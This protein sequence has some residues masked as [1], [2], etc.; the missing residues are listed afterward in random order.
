MNQQVRKVVFPV[1][2]LGTRFLPATKSMPKEMLPV[3]DKPLI[4]HAFEEA[5]AAGIEQ[6][7]FITGR[8]KDAINNHFDHAYE[9]QSLLNEIG[10]EKELAY[11]RDW[12]PAPGNA[13]FIRQQEPLG[14]G[15][16]VWCARHVVG[17]EPFAV[18]LADDLVLGPR[19]CL[20]QMMEVYAEKPGCNLL[21]VEEIP[22]ERSVRY[23][24][25][26]IAEDYG[27]LV[28]A[29]GL[30][31]KPKPEVAPS[32]TAIM[33]RYI[34]QPGIFRHLEETGKGSGGEIQ[35]TD[36]IN[37]MTAETPAYGF[38]FDGKRFDC[39]ERAGFIEANVAYALKVPG[40]REQVLEKLRAMLDAEDHA[41]DTERQ[42]LLA[43]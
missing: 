40:L 42:A 22:L 7:I 11:T 39:G 35:L 8:N 19:P 4:H 28:R 10:R 36:A 37:R 1:G 24:I 18:M 5:L 21:G 3:V 23:G 29:S 33:G 16:A 26:D 31:E 2:G 32:T 6:F 27:K 15:H 38:R 13:I 17:N 41:G 20:A 12:M 9:L 25:L 43:R 14:L 30:V 34:L